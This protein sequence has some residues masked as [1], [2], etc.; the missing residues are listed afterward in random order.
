MT[1]LCQE[2]ASEVCQSH[3]NFHL[4]GQVATAAMMAH[5][6]KFIASKP[7]GQ[8]NY[9]PGT[10]LL[11]KNSNCRLRRFWEGYHAD[12]ERACVQQMVDLL[13]RADSFPDALGATDDHISLHHPLS[14]HTHSSPFFLNLRYLREKS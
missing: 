2:M 3:L 4:K 11:L 6:S 9:L 12:R 7:R 14:S 1:L 13:P 8:A 5:R 10:P